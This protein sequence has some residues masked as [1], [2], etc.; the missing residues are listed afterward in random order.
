MKAGGFIVEWCQ[1]RAE[2]MPMSDQSPDSSAGNPDASRPDPG[3]AEK[4]TG[5]FAERAIKCE[6][7][8]GQ[9][10]SALLK[11]EMK[12]AQLEEI[13]EKLLQLDKMKSEFLSIV[14]HDL[15]AP[16]TCIAGFAQALLNRGAKVCEADRSHYLRL[17]LEESKR[18]SRMAYDFLTLSRIE[19]GAMKIEKRICDL[20]KTVEIIKDSFQRNSRGIKVTVNAPVNLDYIMADEDRLKQALDNIV[21]NAIKYSPRGEVVRL[22]MKDN[23]DEVVISTIDKG[24]GI[25]NS[26]LKT[27]FEKFYRSDDEVSR[28]SRGSGLGLAIAKTV[29]ELHGGRIWAANCPEGGANISFSLPKML[30]S[31]CMPPGG[32]AL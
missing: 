14:S 15:Q 19:S 13:N 10:E 16:L 11:C 8:K 3:K 6:L 31:N 4:Q 2:V 28:S 26:D 9:C 1:L 30:P 32:T 27:I 5:G 12:V 29:V 22:D 23:P 21:A 18:L 24:P 20:R 17:I 7:E 25:K